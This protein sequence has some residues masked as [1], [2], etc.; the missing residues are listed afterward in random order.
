MA[1]RHD[2][3]QDLWLL[4]SSKSIRGGCIHQQIGVEAVSEGPKAN[5]AGVVAKVHNTGEVDA[6]DM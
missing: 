1:Q 5:G 2:I 3:I 4:K 6:P